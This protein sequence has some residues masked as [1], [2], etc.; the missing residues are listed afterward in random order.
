MAPASVQSRYDDELQALIKAMRKDYENMDITMDSNY[1]SQSRI[2]LNALGRKWEK[3]FRRASKDITR[4]FIRGLD[5]FA[6]S[7]VKRSLE[8][9]SGG[10]SIDVPKLP[11][12]LQE[13]ITAAINENVSLIRNIGDEYRFKVEGIVNRS[14]QGEGQ[15]IK[16][17]LIELG[18]MTE[19][20]AHGIAE[21]Q[22]RKVASS[23]NVERLKAVKV[24]RFRWRHSGG[25]SKPRELHLELDGQEFDIDD[26]P[27][28]DEKTG[29]RGFPGQLIHCRCVMIPVHDFSEDGDE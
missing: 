14:I 4:G 9:L 6:R 16:E 13:K 20:R 25:S 18:D 7:N 2:I 17:Q 24:K 29:E 19:R 5:R 15:T 22:T 21:D 27:I 3:V 10:L 23:M 11:G 12:D 8:E 26:P 28:I 1:A